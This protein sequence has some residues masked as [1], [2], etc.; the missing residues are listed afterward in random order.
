MMAKEESAGLDPFS[1]TVL[2]SAFFFLSSIF[3]LLSYTISG[4]IQS[5][6]LSQ[7]TN[8]RLFQALAVCRQHF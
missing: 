7:T 4:I 6:T 5:L 3:K 2:N 8:L 1:Q